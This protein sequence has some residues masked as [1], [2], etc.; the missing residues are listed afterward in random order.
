MIKLILMV[1]SISIGGQVSANDLSV[2]EVISRANQA[3]FYAGDDGRSDAR[4]MIVDAQGG[5]QM[6]QFVIYRKDI[7]SDGADTGDQNFVVVFSRPSD[8]KGTVF[9]VHKKAEG[10]DDRWL[11]LPA[12]D[13][14]KRIAASDNRSSF[15]GSDFFYEDVSGRHPKADSHEI[16]E[17]TDG[18]YVIKSTPKDAGSVEFAYYTM[19]INK[20]T[21][22]PMDVNYF[23]QQ[24]K[25]YRQ[26]EV[27]KVEG[28]Q[29]HAT[30][31][32]SKVSNFNTGGHTL[33]AFRKPQYDIGL[34]EADFSSRAL[35]NPPRK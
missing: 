20:K 28:V 22:L 9:L 2:D 26:V 8:V 34:T 7:M 18:F 25:K 23:D 32:Q 1:L 13:L 5:K 3:S 33:M 31:M 27:L 24:G 16:I 11:Y 14:E 6:R 19:R 4:M 21:F 17:Q 35:R 15:V 30:V 12:L 29:G 10:D